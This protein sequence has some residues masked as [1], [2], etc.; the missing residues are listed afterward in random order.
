VV[1]SDPLPLSPSTS[2]ALRTL[3]NTE[4]DRGDPESADGDIQVEYSY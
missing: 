4:E 3:V 2:S 1:S